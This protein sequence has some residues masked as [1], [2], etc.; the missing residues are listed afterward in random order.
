M[1]DLV[2]LL[3]RLCGPTRAADPLSDA[4]A[5]AVAEYCDAQSRGLY[6]Q[7]SIACLCGSTNDELVATFDRQGLSLRTVL[8]RACGLM[9]SDPYLTAAAQEAFYSRLYRRLYSPFGP[10]I[11]FM[12][13]KQ[14][15]E[16]LRRF[17]SRHGHPHP[18]RV[19]EV[20]CGAGGILQA[21]SEAGSDLAVGCDLDS[22]YLNYGVE[23]GLRLETGDVTTLSKHGH[24]DLLI[25]S[26]VLEHLLDPVTELHHARDLLSAGGCILVAVPG[27]LSIRQTYGSVH[28][29]LQIA[30]VWHFCLRTLDMVF[31]K[32][33]YVRV[34]GDE[35]V[36]AVY[37]PGNGASAAEPDSGLATMIARSLRRTET[38]R[39]IPSRTR[40]LGVL[41][42][43]RNAWRRP[44]RCDAPQQNL[45]EPDRVQS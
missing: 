33:G 14:Y 27:V 17:L 4:E 10:E 20:G 41:A 28:R 13:Q 37:R 1:A 29:F 36:H 24:A 11:L 23:R 15:G 31:G 45:L 19:F 9:R 26:H 44:R 40:I 34:S 35:R 7:A 39:Y 8:C 22:M 25:Y 38:W 42:A 18:R 12:Q 3:P 32:A 21:F 16:G 5:L 6:P 43:C 30:H 2:G